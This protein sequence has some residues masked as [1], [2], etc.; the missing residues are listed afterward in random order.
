MLADAVDL[1]PDLV[2][3]PD[4]LH[5]VTHARACRRHLPGLRVGSQFRERVDANLHAVVVLLLAVELRRD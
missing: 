5:Q 2:G 3:Q 1:E 4:L